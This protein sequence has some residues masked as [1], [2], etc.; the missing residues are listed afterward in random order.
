ME[1]AFLLLIVL[2]ILFFAALLVYRPT[3]RRQCP[4]CRED[5]LLQRVA[6]PLPIKTFL[7]GIPT[8]A[9]RCDKCQ[10]RFVTLGYNGHF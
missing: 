2:I 6:R 4:G 8:K 7:V 10:K 3:L 1:N 9:Y 5:F